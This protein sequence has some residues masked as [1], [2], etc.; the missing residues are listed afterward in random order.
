MFRRR[1]RKL[2]RR[3]QVDE[4]VAPIGR[5][6]LIGTDALGRPPF[7]LAANL[8]DKVHLVSC[9]SELR[10]P[11]DYRRSDI[12]TNLLAFCPPTN[13]FPSE[14]SFSCNGRMVGQ[15]RALADDIEKS[16][17]SWKRREKFEGGAKD[18]T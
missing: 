2:L 15:A 8:E 5:R 14:G 1:L 3:R 17:F 16:H 9:G 18:R 10:L 4:A 6:A 11:S 13:Y 12:S 7:Q